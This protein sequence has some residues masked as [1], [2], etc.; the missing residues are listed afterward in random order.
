MTTI[1]L[2]GTELLQ[3]SCST[4]QD[5]RSKL[6]MWLL[7][8]IVFSW[9]QNSSSSYFASQ[10]FCH[11]RQNRYSTKMYVVQHNALSDSFRIRI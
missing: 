1:I 8:W 10:L 4:K 6:L 5:M 7:Q 3:M 9:R 2:A 11:T